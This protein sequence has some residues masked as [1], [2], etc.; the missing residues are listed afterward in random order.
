DYYVIATDVPGVQHLFGLMAGDVPPT[1]QE[2]VEKLP[3]A[4]PFAVARFWFDRDFAWEYSDFTSLSGYGLTDSITLYHH[5]QQQFIAWAQRT[6]GSVVELHA[7]C[8]KERDFPTQE[9]LLATFTEELYEIVPELAGAKLLHRELVNQK[10]FSGYPTNSYQQ[11]PETRSEIVNL[12]LAG[13]WV[14]MPF[15]CGLMERAISSGFLAANEILAAEGLQRRS[16]L[17]VRPEGVL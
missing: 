3:I 17:T 13:D 7:Y 12:V 15:P 4:D 10:N 6:G 11:R 2:K 16:L 5:I 1:L 8:Y 14:K 9:A